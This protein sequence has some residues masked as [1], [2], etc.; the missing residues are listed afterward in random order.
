M[1]DFNSDLVLHTV[2]YL[3]AMDAGR[4]AATAKRYYYLVNQYQKLR[5]PELVTSS[6]WDPSTKEQVGSKEVVQQ[7]IEGL[8][9]K[10][11]L[12][13]AF[14]SPRS[15]L[16]DELPRRFRG[17]TDNIILGAIAGD[18]Q[19]NQLSNVEHKSNASV[20]FA[21][22]PNAELVPFAINYGPQ[23]EEDIQ[24]LKQKIQQSTDERW[25]KAMIVYACGHGSSHAEAFVATMQQSLPNAAIV[26]GICAAGYV[27]KFTGTK[28]KDELSQMSTRQ[29]KNLNRSLGGDV[30]QAF[31]EKSELVDYVSQLCQTRQLSSQAS[32]LVHCEDTVFGVV[33]G[34]DA[35][36]KSMVSRGVE[37][38]LQGPVQP[39]SPYLVETVKLARPG[40]DA[41][42]FRGD[43]LKPMHMIQQIRN[44]ETGKVLAAAEMINQV[45]QTADFIG[46]K[47]PGSDG[48]EL[49]IMTPYC[50]MA[51]QFLIMTNGSQEEIATMRDAEID[52]FKLTGEACLADMDT[53]VSK[54]KEQTTG[55]KVLG[56]VMYSCNGRG[57][58]RGG[59]IAEAMADASRF[60]KGFPNV[61]CLGFYAGGEIGPLAL[62]GNE[63]VFQTGRVAVQGFT[64]VFALFIVP[65]VERPESYHLDDNDDNVCQFFA[66]LSSIPRPSKQEEQ[67]LITSRQERNLK[68]KQDSVG[69]TRGAGNEIGVAATLALLETPSDDETAVLPP[70]EALFTIDKE[71][72]FGEATE[73]NAQELGLTGESMLNPDTEEWGELYV[74]CSG[75][76]ESTIACTKP[77]SVLAVWKL[78]NWKL[79]PSSA[80]DL[81][82]QCSSTK[83]R[84]LS[85]VYR[86]S[87]ECISLDRAFPGIPPGS[88]RYRDLKSQVSTNLGWVPEITRVEG[89]EKAILWCLKGGT[90]WVVS[91]GSYKNQVGMAALQLVTPDNTNVI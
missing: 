39:T 50:Q 51:Q 30:N 77:S 85:D 62:A 35:P 13:L 28:T 81:F 29:L 80:N 6:S 37:S 17:S 60:S 49:H 90:L 18:I 24:S 67:V 43:D 16:S 7:G 71:K 32:S 56:A 3:N 74:G 45:A 89:N 66:V 70:L 76:G 58:Q 14:N 82:V 1:E 64:A 73:L 47:R 12:I 25:W 54:L 31:V 40:D 69:T 72:G 21:S 26:G 57:P 41:Y 19:V 33:M 53:T 42:L 11:N 55:E 88:A 65:D 27:S 10:P 2:Q 34:G 52:F 4:L 86:V 61:P 23:M 84:R 63:K 5:G 15:A 46:L 87:T 68:W 83:S 59:L 38:V 44:T 36:V 48:F 9:K 79:E 8:Q 78:I 75:G 22:F 20:M 91:D